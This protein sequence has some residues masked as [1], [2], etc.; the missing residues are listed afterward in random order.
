MWSILVHQNF[1]EKRLRNEITEL[2]LTENVDLYLLEQVVSSLLDECFEGVGAFVLFADGYQGEAEFVDGYP[3]GF[4][5]TPVLLPTDGRSGHGHCSALDSAFLTHH[6]ILD[7]R[8]V[9]EPDGFWGRES[10][11]EVRT[12]I[13]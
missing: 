6:Q 2:L 12:L 3:V 7:I 5:R 10:R 1:A 8:A 11:G 13:F 9:L 4:H